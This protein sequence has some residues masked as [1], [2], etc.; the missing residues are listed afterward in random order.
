[1]QT[2]LVLNSERILG[3]AILCVLQAEPDLAVS[4]Y[5]PTCAWELSERLRS[6]GVNTLILD[7]A[8]QVTK[9]VKQSLRRFHIDSGLR[10]IMVDADDNKVSV[11][12]IPEV[13]IYGL[14]DFVDIVRSSR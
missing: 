6:A 3:A 4:G 14:S 7:T 2:I 11:N 9:E 1:V 10:I 5:S 13:P 8:T 12:G